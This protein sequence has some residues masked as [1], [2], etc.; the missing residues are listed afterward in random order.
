MTAFAVR[1]LIEDQIAGD[2]LLG[3]GV[4]PVLLWGPYLW[5]A[6]ETPRA[7]GLT[8]LQSDCEPD[9]I[10]PN[11]DDERKVGALLSAFF[12][13]DPV[14]APWFRAQSAS[15]LL[16]FD[17]LADATVDQTQPGT[18]FGAQSSLRLKRVGR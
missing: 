3:E 17:M 18:N 12:N 10:H 15:R 13:Q 6:G 11:D 1:W 4:A 8:L 5:A 14:A 7:D 16:R 2:P 9:F